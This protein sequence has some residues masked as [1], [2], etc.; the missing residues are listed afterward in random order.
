[1]RRIG[2]YTKRNSVRSAKLETNKYLLWFRNLKRWQKIGVIVGPI[3]AIMILIPLLTYAYFARDISD[4]ERLMNRNNTGIVLTDTKGEIIYQIGRAKHRDIVPL[5]QISEHTRKALLASEDKNFYEHGG[6]SIISMVG[7]LYGNVL[8][9]DRSFGGSTITQQLAKNTLLT[10]Q[11]SYL[12]KY[13]ELSIA[14]AIERTYSKDEILEMYLNSIFF[15]GSSFGIQDAAEVYF[16]KKAADLDLAESTML[17]GLLPAPN[18]YSPIYGSMEYAKERQEVVLDRMLDNGVITKDE[19]EAALAKELA[20]AP[21]KS[22]ADESPAPHFSQ[23]VIGELNKRY[24]EEKVARSGFQV[25]TT[26]DLTTQRQLQ[27]DINNNMENIRANGGSNAGAVAINPTTGGVQGLV[28]SYSWDDPNFGKVNMATSARQPGSSFKPLYYSEA[29]AEGVITPV[30]TFRDEATNFNGYEPQNALRQ[31]YGDVTVRK[32]LNWSLNIP[33]VKVMQKLGVEK[34]AEAAKR[35]GITTIDE[36]KDYNLS[37]ALGS[38]EAKLIDM[39]HAYAAFANAGNQMDVKLI[40]TVKNK[41]D[42][43]IYQ[44]PNNSK[45]VISEEG[46]YLISNILSDNQARAGMFGASLNVSGKKVAVKTGTTD[47]QR[48]AWTIGYTPQLAVGVW[49]GNNDNTPMLSGGGDMA[50]PIWRSS[51]TQLLSGVTA[52]GFKRP[53]GIAERDVCYGTGTLANTGGLNTYKEVF[54]TTALPPYGCDVRTQDEVDRE[55]AAEKAKEEQEK[56]QKEKDAAAAEGSGDDD[57]STDTPGAG[58]ET[59]PLEG[60]E[61]G[62]NP[63]TNLP[64]NG[65]GTTPTPGGPLNP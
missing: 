39:T 21:Q 60:G 33:S 38:V 15:G 16:G 26:L 64:G 25:K 35:M 46:A 36:K 10:D 40:D 44:S 18:A 63:G 3:L 42:A 41:Y 5:N 6:F 14:V 52:N 31:F 58:E 51:M 11:K 49:V 1:M 61:T 54:L 48:D 4:K 2:K 20:Y 7:A 9:G 57:P 32:A 29:L 59:D 8:S 50:G 55:K 34:S 22:E 28:G 17:I 56:Q 13:Q 24:G 19:K 62:E 30:T 12:R 53:A 47:N 45:R 37:L 43:T 65:G 27:Q 23:M